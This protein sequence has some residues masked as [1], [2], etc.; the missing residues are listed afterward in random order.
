VKPPSL[1][2]PMVTDL[3]ARQEAELRFSHSSHLH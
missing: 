1:A 3:V 2:M